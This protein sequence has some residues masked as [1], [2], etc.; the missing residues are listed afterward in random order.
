MT[1]ASFRLTDR[2]TRANQMLGSD[3]I[4]NMLVGGSRSGKTFL[5]VRAVIIRALAKVSRHAVL[6]FRFN[7]VKASIIYDTLPKVMELCFPGVD[8]RSHLDKS[9]WFY[10]LPNKSEIWFGGLDDKERTEKILGQEYS[11]IYLNECSQI[12]WSSRNMAITRLAQNSGLR[13]K[14]YYDCNPPSKAHWTHK[15]FI[16]KRDPERA[17][18]LPDPDNYQ[19]LVMNPK[20][21]VDNLPPE[22]TKMLQSLP[23]RERKRFW[24]GLFADLD[25]G[26]LWYPE[27]LDAQRVLDGRLPDTQRIIIAVDPSGCRGP[28]D[29]RSDEVGITVQALGING[30]GYLLEDLSGHHSAAQWPKDSEFSLPAARSRL[31]CWGSK[32]RWR[33]G[34]PSNTG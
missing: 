27:L 14:M 12:P 1:Q 7:H 32:L 29:T 18:N 5:L 19:S 23:A 8:E 17:G 9:D 28:E 26:A 25:E 30:N 4:H 6:R 21:N 34:P 20:D 16:E 13:L 31:C 24:E 10:T 22:Y 33:H 2:Q 15:I 3:S 11:T